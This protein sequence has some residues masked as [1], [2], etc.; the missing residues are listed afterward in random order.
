MRE[1]SNHLSGAN[2]GD[3]ERDV[4]ETVALG[5]ALPKSA[6]SMFDTRLYNQSQGMGQG[7]GGDDDYSVYSKPFS[8]G[9]TSFCHY[10]FFS[11]PIFRSFKFSNPYNLC[12]GVST[13]CNDPQKLIMHMLSLLDASA[14]SDAH[15]CSRIHVSH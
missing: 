6:D 14:P 1:R 10:T 8:A 9:F 7:F 15:E 3:E 4:S 2:R 11:S 5:K 12:E 13:E